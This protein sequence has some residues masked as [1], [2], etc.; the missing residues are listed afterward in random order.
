VEQVGIKLAVEGTQTVNAA[1]DSARGLEGALT[2]VS[3]ASARVSGTAAGAAQATQQVARAGADG[4]T[5][6]LLLGQAVD[7]AQYGLRALTNQVP[8]LAMA[9]GMGMGLAGA[10]SMVAVG[11]NLLIANW[12]T[13]TAAFNTD[14][15]ERQ[16]E[17]A[18]EFAAAAS[19]AAKAAEGIRGAADTAA[20]GAFTNQLRASLKPGQTGQD[21]ENALLAARLEEKMAA[22]GPVDLDAVRAEVQTIFAAAAKGSVEA[23]AQI[24]NIAFGAKGGILGRFNENAG[25]EER[26]KAWEA[27]VQLDRAETQLLE[28]QEAKE[29]K[30]AEAAQRHADA[31]ERQAQ[32]TIRAAEASERD[33]EAKANEQQY[34]RRTGMRTEMF[35]QAWGNELAG[36][37]LR[38]AQR[39]EDQETTDARLRGQL[40]ARMT[41]VPE[42]M[43]ETVADDLLEK[44]RAQ[45]ER[46][47]VARGVRGDVMRAQLGTAYAQADGSTFLGQ[48]QRQ[49][50]SRMAQGMG[51]AAGPGDKQAKATEDLKGATTELKRAAELIQRVQVRI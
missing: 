2:R 5:R 10:L 49:Q 30:A 44:S 17:Q 25:T 1:A 8:Q 48:A 41:T 13:L 28:E 31:L 20:G 9:F 33:A 39:G 42:G 12:D 51:L 47:A 46:F 23:S 29:R 19:E 3:T 43:R 27:Q 22:G 26:K 18:R 4:A 34:D 50:L 36:A 24:A 21:F 11:V 32:A 37:Q 7:D 6:M 45:A 15:F 14:P 16:A 35:G 40:M 38:A